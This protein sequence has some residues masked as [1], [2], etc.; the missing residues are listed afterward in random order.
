MKTPLV[1][2]LAT[3][4]FTVTWEPEG[5]WL[6]N[7]HEEKFIAGLRALPKLLSLMQAV[8]NVADLADGEHPDFADS[9]A[10]VVQ[11]MPLEDIREVMIALLA[12]EHFYNEPWPDAF[13]DRAACEGWN[14]FENDVHGLH[15]E[16]DDAV[17]TFETD[18][19]AIEL[20]RTRAQAGAPYA[21]RALAL[22]LKAHPDDAFEGR[23][24]QA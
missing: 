2:R 4:H 13:A 9:G 5:G 15:I 16:R 22:H 11:A 12:P 8:S 24:A 18:D 17:D 19:D 14:I 1:Q 23:G 20:V 3:G 10:D 7:L 21:I 6:D